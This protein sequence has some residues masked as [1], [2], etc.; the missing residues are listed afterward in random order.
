MRSSMPCAESAA[1]LPRTVS[2]PVTELSPGQRRL[3]FVDG[4]GLVLF[5]IDGTV[6]AIDNTCPHQGASLANGKLEGTRL[7][8][9]AHGLHFDLAASDTAALC[10]KRFP[11]GT[12]DGMLTVVLEDPPPTA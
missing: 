2:I 10:L 6:Y 9:P 3:V 8:C 12:A 7:Q 11:V 5:N 4:R 1:C